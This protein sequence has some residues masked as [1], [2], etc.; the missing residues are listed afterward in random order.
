M[1]F[2]EDPPY[3]AG[4]GGAGGF[5]RQNSQGYDRRGAQNAY[6]QGGQGC[7]QGAGSDFYD[8][9]SGFTDKSE[10]QLM[11]ELTSAVDRM[12]AEGTFDPASLERLYV[13][14]APFLSEAQRERMRRII[15]MLIK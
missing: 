1:N 2:W 8:R 5:D 10:E 9:L 11:S 6:G 3:G 12:K 13:T 15:D 7:A 14:A 4:R